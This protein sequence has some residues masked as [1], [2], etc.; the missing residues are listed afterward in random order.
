MTRL[1]DDFECFY[2]GKCI[3]ADNHCKDFQVCP[4]IST[5]GKCNLCFYQSVCRRKEKEKYGK[6]G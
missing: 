3:N 4:R 2:M 6:D 1:C 5:L